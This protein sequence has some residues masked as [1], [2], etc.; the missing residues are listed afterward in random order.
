M[1]IAVLTFF[2]AFVPIF[3]AIFAGAVAVLSA[4]VSNGWL[5]AL[6][7]MGL[8]LL[9]QQAESSLLNPLLLGRAL[10]LHPL[11]VLT[12]ASIGLLLAGIAGGVLAVPT[13]AAAVSFFA[14]LK[15]QGG[16]AGA[17]R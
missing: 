9:V 3:G 2:S 6:A 16:G 5:T 11:A 14:P 17:R 8:V 12:A 10:S 7:V 4:F 13:L 15:A 1:A